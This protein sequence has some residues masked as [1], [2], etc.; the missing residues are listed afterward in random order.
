MEIASIR[1]MISRSLLKQIPKTGARGIRSSASRAAKDD[2]S[3]IDSFKLPS[4]TSINEWE[5][6]YDFVPKTIEPKVP[7]VTPEAVKKD[8]AQDKKATVE[9]EMLNQE[10]TS[11]KVE[12]NSASVLHGG[13]SVGDEP[14]FLQDRG[15]KPVDVSHKT[16]T[17]TKKQSKPANRDKYVQSS[18]NPNINKADVVNLG[19]RE[20]DHKLSHVDPQAR[21]VDDLEH[22]EK[23]TQGEGDAQQA[24]GSGPRLVLGAVAASIAGFFGYQYFLAAEDGPKVSAKK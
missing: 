14:E 13:E 3:T 8:I 16:A 21:V 5:F 24:S 12:A 7:P 4:Q 9:K 1:R 18:I 20:V 22:D 23:H 11:V 10:M 17:G 15:S 2:K 6:K 19:Q